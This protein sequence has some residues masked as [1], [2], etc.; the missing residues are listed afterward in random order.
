MKGMKRTALEPGLLQVFRIFVGLRLLLIII[1]LRLRVLVQ[2]PRARLYLFLLLVESA[3]LLG[4]LSWSW[5]REQLGKA[6]LPLALI[7]AS[8]VP[9]FEQGLAMLLREANILQGDSATTGVWGLLILLLVPLILVSWQYSLAAVVG[10]ISGTAILEILVIV[11]IGLVAEIQIRAPIGALV[12]RSLLFLLIGSIL[13]RL[14]KAQREQRE[15]L[16]A[17][18]L[19]LARHASIIEQ[20]A[21]SRERNRLARELHDTLAHTLSGLAVQLEAV[22]S[23]WDS[24]QEAV[25]EMLY[26]A[27]ETT[28]LGLKES[29]R[30]IQ[31]LRASPLEDLGLAL[32]LRDL[33]RSAEARAD[34]S[35][36]LHLPDHIDDWPS[37][38]EQ[39]LYRIAEQSIANVVQHAEAH[40]LT[41]TLEQGDGRLTLIVRDDGRGFDPEEVEGEGRFGLKGMHE[42]ARLIGGELVIDSHPG[43]GASVQLTVEEGHDPRLDM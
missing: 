4:Y 18:N 23:L 32:A 16:A 39:G 6:Y 9:I 15:A 41:L 10:F 11:P 2:E 24:D 38:I 5:L 26:E 36:E 7:Y 14:M 40:H 30:A 28:R 21:T 17:A 25:R 35:L 8:T 3:I 31:A 37:E 22:Q 13:V 20:L 29:R 42:R 33:A 12:V 34:L 27:Q 19:E 1:G 43:R